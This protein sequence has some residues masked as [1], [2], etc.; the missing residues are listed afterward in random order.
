MPTRSGSSPRSA[1]RAAPPRALARRRAGGSGRGR[2][3]RG[4]S[5]A[6]PGCRGRRV[7]RAPRSGAARPSA[8]GRPSRSASGTRSPAAAGIVL[9]VGDE[10]DARRRARRGG[11]LQQTT[12]RERLIVGVRRDH[13]HPIL[14]RQGS[15]RCTHEV[16]TVATSVSAANGVK[17]RSSVGA[18]TS[19][20]GPWS[21]SVRR[22]WRPAASTRGPSLA[23][24]VEL[25][26]CAAGG[27][28]RECVGA[29][30]RD[31]EHDRGLRARRLRRQHPA[32]D[33]EPSDRK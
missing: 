13:Q 27:R 32:G 30:N 1:R 16:G 14:R 4:R 6:A 24:A 20:R 33:A 28:R 15:Q 5:H 3:A 12:R 11:A 7:R 23:R 22:T 18:H 8:S 2:E 29:G 9:A 10:D 31:V 26:V 25:A 17:P 21:A 19:A